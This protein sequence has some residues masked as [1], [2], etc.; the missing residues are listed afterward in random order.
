LQ[1]TVKKICIRNREK[2]RS[3]PAGFFHHRL[4][5]TAAGPRDQPDRGTD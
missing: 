3:V 4:R 2:K 5:R 1:A